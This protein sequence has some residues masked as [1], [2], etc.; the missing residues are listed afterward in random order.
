VTRVGMIIIII[1]H[2]EFIVQHFYLKQLP[3]TIS[4]LYVAVFPLLGILRLK[5]T[6]SVTVSNENKTGFIEADS[7]LSSRRQILFAHWENGQSLIRIFQT[8]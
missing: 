6:P 8:A 1:R 7:L 3:V 5:L 4:Y 2:K